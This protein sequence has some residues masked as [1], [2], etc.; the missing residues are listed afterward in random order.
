M[1]KIILIL[2]LLGMFTGCTALEKFKEDWAAAAN[3]EREYVYNE[4]TGKYEPN[5]IHTRIKNAYGV[6]AAK[7][8]AKWDVNYENIMY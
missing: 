3:G 1:K 5:D 7:G 2:G 8:T 6:E 4:N